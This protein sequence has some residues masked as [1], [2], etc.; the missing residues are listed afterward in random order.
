[1]GRFI[2]SPD[3]SEGHGPKWKN[4]QIRSEGLVRAWWV[5]VTKDAYRG[6]RR[7]S[8][9]EVRGIRLGGLGPAQRLWHAV[10][11]G[12]LSRPPELSEAA[13]IAR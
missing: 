6:S 7:R 3:R 9:V 2:K 4:G 11:L 5:N 10:V 1:M 12:A 8:M 13:L